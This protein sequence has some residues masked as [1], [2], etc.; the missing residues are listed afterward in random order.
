M[1]NF[2]LAIWVIF[3][4][5]LAI[6]IATNVIDLINN[7]RGKSPYNTNASGFRITKITKS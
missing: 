2:M 1:D 5:A 4:T 6:F 3:M 7:K